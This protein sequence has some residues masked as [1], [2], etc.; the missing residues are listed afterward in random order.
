MMQR[1]NNF[2]PT[3]QQLNNSNIQ[4][5]QQLQRS[6]QQQFIQQQLKNRKFPISIF[7]PLP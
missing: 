4:L 3:I 2:P 1:S 6:R 7:P 5:Q